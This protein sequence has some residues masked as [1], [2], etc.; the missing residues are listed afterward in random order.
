VEENIPTVFQGAHDLDVAYRVAV[1][2]WLEELDEALGT[3]RYAG[4]VLRVAVAGVP[5]D[6]LARMAVPDPLEVQPDSVVDSDS[7]LMSDRP[8]GPY[9]PE[10]L[11]SPPPSCILASPMTKLAHRIIIP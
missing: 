11:T 3:V 5:C 2:E 6:C 4:A 1:E 8:L 7:W 10:G 9:H